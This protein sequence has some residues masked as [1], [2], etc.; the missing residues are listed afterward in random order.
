MSP[1]QTMCHSRL[2]QHNGSYEPKAASCCH[3]MPLVCVKAHICWRTW[4]RLG[5]R[6]PLMGPNDKLGFLARLYSEE[7]VCK[8]CTDTSRL[9][10]DA[11]RGVCVVSE[12]VKLKLEL[13]SSVM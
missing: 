9:M 11:N 7:H 1:G 4:L 6:Q 12:Q 2:L 8:G 10:K 13:F 3:Y 5:S